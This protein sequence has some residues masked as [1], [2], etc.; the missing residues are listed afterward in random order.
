V[1]VLV[2]SDWHLNDKPRDRY[3]HDWVKNE[4]PRLIVKH[5]VSTLLMLGDLTDEF[6]NH[7]AALVNEIVIHLQRLTD[8]CSHQVFIVR[9]N[10]DYVDPRCPFFKF[11]TALHKITWVNSPC[12]HEVT[13]LRFL[14]L[15]HTRDYKTDW[16]NVNFN[17]ADICF[18]HNT[19]DG[20]TSESGV[21]LPGIPPSAIPEDLHVISGDIHK[22]QIVGKNIEYVGS[23]YTID[24][25]DDFKPRVMLLT[26]DS[27]VK[28]IAC[29]GPQKRLLVPKDEK[30]LHKLFK[31][32]AESND[33][34]KLRYTVG[35]SEIENW[36]TIKRQ[37]AADALELG[38]R[39]HSIDP[40][41]PAEATSS[42]RYCARAAKVRRDDEVL[43][44]YCK[45]RGVADD[46]VTTG[47]EIIKG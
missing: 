47:L 39:L 42:K 33:I 41:M 24:F 37:I 28:S 6:D 8:L 20:T 40:V 12:T 32:A 3:R 19:F 16:A 17:K 13:G 21:L 1:A 15:P 27:N 18:A 34:V 31:A 46:L 25:G 11:T 36:P 22:R 30:D 9:G 35:K 5:N 29:S 26:D 14:F 10:H 45:T 44:A 2:T 7:P 38:V 4:L 43:D 23:P